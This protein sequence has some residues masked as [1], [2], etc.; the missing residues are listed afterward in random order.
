MVRK[1]VCLFVLCTTLS[2]KAET[3]LVDSKNELGLGFILGSP[4]ALSARK[5]L[6]DGHSVDLGF[7]YSWGNSLQGFADYVFLFPNA[8]GDRDFKLTPFVGV[9]GALTLILAGRKRSLDDDT[10]TRTLTAARFPLGISWWVPKSNVEIFA[11]IVPMIDVIPG[12]FPDFAGGIG[13]RIYI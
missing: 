5:F 8:W 7:G 6:R 11:E 9:G 12:L 13:F 3:P 1:L 2:L 4:T 10:E